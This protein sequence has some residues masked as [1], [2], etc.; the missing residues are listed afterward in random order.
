MD[1]KQEIW[2]VKMI[3][4]EQEEEWIDGQIDKCM[5]EK[6]EKERERENKK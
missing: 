2:D 5:N 3:C 1:R 4:K 6:G